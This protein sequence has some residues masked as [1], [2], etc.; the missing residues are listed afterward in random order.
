MTYEKDRE[1]RGTDAVAAWDGSGQQLLLWHY[2]KSLGRY[3]NN[4][5]EINPMVSAMGVAFYV[6][7]SGIIVAMLVLLFGASRGRGPF[8]WLLPAVPALLP[9]FFLIDYSAWLWWYGHRLNDMGA[10]TVKAFMPTVF[11]DGKVAQFS[12]HSYPSWGFGLMLVLS[13]VLALMMIMR[14]KQLNRSAVN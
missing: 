12:T 14:R 7:F 5:A 4:P 3:F 11:G 9:V 2:E 8:Y 6:V 10:F 13:V 1:R